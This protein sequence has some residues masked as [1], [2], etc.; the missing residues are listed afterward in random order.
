MCV[1][2]YRATFVNG[3]SI[4]RNI[5]F[6]DISSLEKFAKFVITGRKAKIFFQKPHVTLS[7]VHLKVFVIII[8]VILQIHFNNF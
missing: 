6:Y 2:I 3:V 8:I 5:L 1:F 7:H 4:E